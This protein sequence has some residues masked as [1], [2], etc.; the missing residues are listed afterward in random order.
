MSKGRSNTFNKYFSKIFIINLKDKTQRLEKTTKQ[1]HKNGIKY[2]RFEAVDGRCSNPKQCRSKKRELEKKYKVKINMKSIPAASLIIGTLLILKQM[3]KHKWKRVLICEDDIELSRNLI[4]KFDKGIK[5]VE[6]VAKDYDI[7]YLGCGNKCGVRG[8]SIEQNS[9]N[10][11]LT[12]L[13]IVEGANYNWF[14]KYKNDI[15][16]PCKDCE[17]IS[18]Y[19]TIP[20]SPYGG[21]A[22]VYSLKGA[23]KILKYINNAPWDAIDMII[24]EAIDEG[25]IKSVAFDPPIIMHEAGAFRPDSDID[26]DW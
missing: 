18:K 4:A 22:Y 24:P 13:S 26:W 12:T 23:K 19:L 5:D 7:L 6:K 9:I 16:F 15:R 11:Y 20:S 3:V 14:V 21:W 10:K 25:V 8:L 17:I 2:T 1:F